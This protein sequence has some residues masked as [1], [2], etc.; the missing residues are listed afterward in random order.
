MA[1]PAIGTV[2]VAY[3]GFNE[4]FAMADG[5]ETVQSQQRMTEMIESPEEE[6]D[7]ES[8]TEFFRIEIV[9]GQLIPLAALVVVAQGFAAKIKASPAPPPFQGGLAEEVGEI[10]D[11]NYLHRAALQCLERPESIPG[12][13]IENAFAAQILWDVVSFEIQGIDTGGLQAVRQLNPMVPE[14]YF[15][16]PGFELKVVHGCI[17]G[18]G[19]RERRRHAVLRFGSSAAGSRVAGQAATDIGRGGV[20]WLTAPSHE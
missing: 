12:A 13:D 11:G 10:V 1:E 7:I 20:G 9:D 4:D 18:E 19:L 15:F 17:E 3:L 16:Q 2:V 14:G 6:D 5:T 8:A